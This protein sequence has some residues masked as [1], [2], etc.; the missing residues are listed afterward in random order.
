M[1]LAARDNA[2][3]EINSTPLIDV[4]LVLL[5]ILLITLPIMTHAV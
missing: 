5:V 2:M 4:M 1:P 3:C